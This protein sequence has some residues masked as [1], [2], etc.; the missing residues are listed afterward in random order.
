M[1]SK[2]TVNQVFI[3]PSATQPFLVLP[4]SNRVSVLFTLNYDSRKV[5]LLNLRDHG[6]LV[7]NGLVAGALQPTFTNAYWETLVPADLFES[8]DW[9]VKMRDT[10][11]VQSELV[12]PVFPD[13]AVIRPNLKRLC[14]IIFP[15][16]S[17]T[18]FITMNT[19]EQNGPQVLLA[20]N[21]PLI[22]L[23]KDH[24]EIARATFWLWHSVGGVTVNFWETLEP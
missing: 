23:L 24:G 2:S 22:F 12:V 10:L 8:T 1:L 11:A 6:A 15:P 18:L 14:L 16:Q 19:Q 20:S 4:N 3:V 7:T 5:M 9:A 13:F 17:G 21:Q